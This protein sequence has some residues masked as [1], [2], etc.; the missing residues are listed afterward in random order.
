MT[1][2]QAIDALHGER[3]RPT[4]RAYLLS[5]RGP[6]TSPSAASQVGRRQDG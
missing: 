3:D 4:L 6:A 5:L 1:S 2:A